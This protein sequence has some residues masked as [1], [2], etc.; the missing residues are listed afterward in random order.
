MVPSCRRSSIGVILHSGVLRGHRFRTTSL[1][2]LALL[3]IGLGSFALSEPS[4]H[5]PSTSAHETASPHGVVTPTTTTTTTAPGPP[6]RIQDATITLTDPSR[7]TPARGNVPGHAGRTLVTVIRRPSGALGPLPLVVFAHGWNSNPSVY[8]VLLDAWAAAGFLVAA[9]T[10]PDS[11]DTLPGSPVS[12]YP[13]QARDMSFVISSLLGGVEGP[14]DP[15]RIAVAGHSDGGTDIALLALNPHY[16]DPRIRAY[17]SLSG[18]IPS[19]VSGPWGVSTAGA[20]LVAVG[21]ADQYGL[22]GPAT[23]IYQTADMTKVMLTVAGGDHLTTFI[24]TSAPEQAVRA[25]TVRFLR[26]ALS[27]SNVSTSQ[28]HEALSPTGDPAITLQAGSG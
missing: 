21:S 4:E 13:E 16:A 12:N 22:L 27:S 11:T 7:A 26:A 14:V 28:L 5:H 6:F 1:G 3:V 8:E 20:L 18:E 24:G 25:E 17:L 9:P 23:E 15:S 2:L 10:F 19:G